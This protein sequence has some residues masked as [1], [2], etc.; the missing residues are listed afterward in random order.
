MK[1]DQLLQ[2]SQ[3]L[4]AHQPRK[5]VTVCISLPKPHTIERLL[6]DAVQTSNKVDSFCFSP[7]GRQKDG[8]VI[9]AFSYQFGYVRTTPTNEQLL[10]AQCESC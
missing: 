5:A 9:L 1:T 6:S 3:S 4:H 7:F 10:A 8:V 2:F